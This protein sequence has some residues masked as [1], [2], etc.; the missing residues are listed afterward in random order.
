MCI[1]FQTNIK[2]A[3]LTHLLNHLNARHK[4]GICS[5]GSDGALLPASRIEVPG[6]T[7]SNAASSLALC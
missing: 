7:G 5:S 6:F 4:A 1:L 2:A 3:F